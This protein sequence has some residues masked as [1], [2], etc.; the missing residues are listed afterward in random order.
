MSKGKKIIISILA[1]LVALI[2]AVVV[3]YYV[4]FSP[5][6]PTT[7]ITNNVQI[8]ELAL[9]KKF[10][11]KDIDLSFKGISATSNAQFS[12]QELTNLAI[13][14]VNQSPEAKKYVTGLEVKI[15]DGNIV[16]YVTINYKGI[17]LEG[18]L[19]FEPYAKD[20]KGLFHYVSGNVGFIQ[21]PKDLI[22][23]KLE[24]NSVVQFDKTNGN[25]VLYFNNIKQIKIENIYTKEDN[26]NIVF[27]GNLKFF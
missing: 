27:K 1:I 3:T 4:S 16:I 17:P 10:I 26:I 25:I 14:A 2:I 22:F 11:P 23:N 6:T 21:I 13:Y 9:A 5:K 8:N 20:G 15:T 7:P 18:K 24:N 12:A 19:I